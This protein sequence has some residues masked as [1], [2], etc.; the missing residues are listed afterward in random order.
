MNIFFSEI[1]LN[2]NLKILFYINILYIYI[3]YNI[4]VLYKEYLYK[5]QC[6]KLIKIIFIKL[7]H[8]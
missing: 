1:I 4:F 8:S 6:F 3:F 5:I 2:L 7:F